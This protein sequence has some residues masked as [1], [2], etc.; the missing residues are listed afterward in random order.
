[1]KADFLF[2]VFFDQNRHAAGGITNKLM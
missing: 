2:P 1:M